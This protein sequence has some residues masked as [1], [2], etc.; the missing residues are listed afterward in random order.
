MR[1][2]CK[3]SMKVETVPFDYHAAFR[4]GGRYAEVV[5]AR[6]QASGVRCYAPAIQ[7]AQTQEE[8]DFMTMY[9]TDIEFDWMETG[10][11][12]KSSSRIFSD[13]VDDYPYETLFVDTVSGFDAKVVKPIAYVFVSQETAGMVCLSPKT[14]SSWQQVEAFDRK[15]EITDRFY[16]VNKAKLQSFD[17]LVKWLIQNQREGM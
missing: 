6:L 7:I 13:L 17:S 15:R 16:S 5:A 2:Q 4:E 10:L 11:E 12:V 8:I 14:K 3:R 1:Q 9:E